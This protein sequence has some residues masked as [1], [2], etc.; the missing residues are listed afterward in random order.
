ML[1]LDRFRARLN[2]SAHRTPIW[3][4]HE[5]ADPIGLADDLRA[6]W[7]ALPRFATNTRRWTRRQIDLKCFKPIKL[8]YIR[9]QLAQGPYNRVSVRF[10]A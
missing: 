4:A 10:F 2:L 7:V 6:A 1:R 3:R 5:L 9:I 8:F